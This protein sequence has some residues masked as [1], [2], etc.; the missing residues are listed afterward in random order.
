MNKALIKFLLAGGI[1]LTALFAAFCAHTNEENPHI[2]DG[3]SNRANCINCH[4]ADPINK[5]SGILLTKNHSF[6]QKAFSKN[7]VAMCSNCHNPKEGHKVGLEIDFSVPAD[8]PLD[9]NKDITCLTCHYTHG[10]L[11]SDRPQ[12]SH[13]FMDSLL[14]SERLKKTFLLRRNNSDG[15]LCLICHN[16]NQGSK[17]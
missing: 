2:I 3:N 6:N 16:P 13:S 14:N 11:D 10:R 17:P 15:E 7:A 9:E 8:M 1:G 12:A 4:I 5:E